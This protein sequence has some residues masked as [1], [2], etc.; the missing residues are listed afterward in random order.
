M[1]QSTKAWQQT[2]TSLALLDGSRICWQLNFDP[3]EGK[4]YFH[5][6]TNPAGEVVTA[7]RPEDHPWHRGIWW[8]WKFLNG[9]N[10]WEENKN[11]ISD[12]LTVLKETTV[13]AR[14]DF[15]AHIEQQIEYAP[16]LAERRRLV[17]AAN[18]VFWRS[19]FTALQS[20][21]LDRTPIAGETNGQRWGGYAGLSVRLANG[22]VGLHD[23]EGRT[24]AAAIHGQTA[25]WVEYAGV[26]VVP[27]QPCRWYVWSDG[28]S[29]FSP[30][31]LFDGPV[32]LEAG[33]QWSL[34]YEIFLP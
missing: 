5:P 28:M 7:L 25:A 12:G 9:V 4:S 6:V 29:Y 22:V 34:N 1:E 3:R 33:Q 13:D 20:V 8:S 30:A 21:K 19:E 27:E 24:D 11:G 32:G 14:P 15:T 18:R 10:Y 16:L 26:R 31:V 17:I 23:S 2:P